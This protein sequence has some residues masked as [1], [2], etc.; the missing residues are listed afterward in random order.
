MNENLKIFELMMK[1]HW[2]EATYKKEY[3]FFS[4]A[5]TLFDDNDLIGVFDVRNC[6][7]ESD[8]RKYVE[9]YIPA[10]GMTN[11]R[12]NVW[13][14]SHLIYNFSSKKLMFRLH[15]NILKNFAKV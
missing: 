10:I 11:I 4:F 2:K 3:N 12:S 13:Q 6:F 9:L 1:Y 7:T 8:M 5:V 14:F 15:K